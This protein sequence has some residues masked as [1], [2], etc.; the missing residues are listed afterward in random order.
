MRSA[1]GSLIMTLVA[2]AILALAMF[3]PAVRSCGGVIYP[4]SGLI[5]M[6]WAWLLPPHAFGALAALFAAVLLRGRPAR[7][8]A[9]EIA[10]IVWAA[11]AGLA[12]TSFFAL[13]IEPPAGL[14]LAA[15]SLILPALLIVRAQERR[16]R[17]VRALWVGALECTV[18]YLFWIAGFSLDP[19]SKDTLLA[20]T[21]IAAGASVLLLAAGRRLQS[22]TPRWRPGQ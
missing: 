21:Y 15:G 9:L 8:T 19:D 7:N 12:L 14:A 16:W 11:A 6:D 3:L 5:E 4:A 22:L 2:G 17:A 18:W 10:L 20:G 13:A 1:S